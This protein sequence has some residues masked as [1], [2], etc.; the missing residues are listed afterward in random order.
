MLTLFFVDCTSKQHDKATSVT[1]YGDS[2]RAGRYI[3]TRGIKIYYETYGRGRP[4]VL[5]HGN[6]GSLANFKYQIPY[7][8]KNYKVIAIDSRAQGKSVDTSSTLNYEMMADDFNA[9]L[10]SLH[11]DSAYVI[12]WSDGGINGLL[13]SIRHPDKVSKLAITGANLVPDTSVFHPGTNAMISNGLKQLRSGK[14]DAETRNMIKLIHMMEVE[15]HISPADLQKIQCPVLVIGGD[16]D[17]IKPA[18]TLEI[19]Q[20][21]PRAYLW[22]LPAAGHAT[23]Q[24]YRDEFNTKVNDFFSHPYHTVKWNDWE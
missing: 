4:L 10:D 13:L 17:A 19:F 15:P 21:I 5:I 23:L 9:V 20:N 7:F 22:I 12:G 8:E 16:F 1:Q 3:N 2:A 6:G 11:L 18:H 24:H 14:Q